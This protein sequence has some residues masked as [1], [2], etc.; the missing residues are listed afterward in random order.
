MNKTNL[1]VTLPGDELRHTTL[2]PDQYVRSRIQDQINYF[3]VKTRTLAAQL[4]AM[5]VPILIAGGTGTF[6]AAIQLDVW[7]AQRPPS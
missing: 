1:E 4:T 5:H 2:T 6:L 3:K 7:A